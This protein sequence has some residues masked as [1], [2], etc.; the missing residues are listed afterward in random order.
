LAAAAAF[1]IPPP[2]AASA[3]SPAPAGSSA[4]SSATYGSTLGSGTHTSGS[5]GTYQ[6]AP[7][8]SGAEAHPPHRDYEL[9]PD[10]YGRY[11]NICAA[12]EQQA[13][14]EL[15]IGRIRWDLGDTAAAAAHEQEADRIAGQANSNGCNMYE[16]E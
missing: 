15:E 12:W 16:P 4:S 7:T 14:Q 1:A 11:S 13:N 3:L 10:D 9:G 2:A 6:P 5:A 8:A